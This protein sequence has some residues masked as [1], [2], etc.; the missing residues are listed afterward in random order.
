MVNLLKS[1][2]KEMGLSLIFIAH[3]LSVVKHISDRVMVMY[4][5]NAVEIGEGDA[6]F[7]DLST[8]I[9]GTDVGCSYSG[10]GERAQ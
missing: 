5:G 4:L 1:L 10:S 6:L 2:Q 9:Q 8:L 7:D 3:D